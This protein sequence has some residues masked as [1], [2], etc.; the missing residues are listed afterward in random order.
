MFSSIT[1]S[2]GLLKDRAVQSSARAFI[3]RKIEKLGTVTRLTLDSRQKQ[4]TVEAS[5]KGEASAITVRIGAYELVER[6]GGTFLV[7][8]QAEASREW[9][10]HGLNEFLVG[11][12]VKLPEA[13]RMAL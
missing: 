1:N 5:L 3:N 9:I 13:L 11:R 12:E 6:D 2:M 10:T 7:V 4:I 8:R